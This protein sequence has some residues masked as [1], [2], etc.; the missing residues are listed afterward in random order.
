MRQRS[1]T[2]NR[3]RLAFSLDCLLAEPMMKIVLC[4]V[5]AAGPVAFC[6]TKK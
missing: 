5:R 6:G 1:K 4:E 2:N 3:C